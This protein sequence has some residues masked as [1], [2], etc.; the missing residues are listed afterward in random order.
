MTD[1]FDF[2]ALPA[3]DILESIEFEEIYQARVA[4]FKALAPQYADA[5][6]LQSDPLSVC[7][8]VESYRELLLR[9]RIN[10][11]VQSNLLATA[12]DADL[13]QLGLFYGVLRAADEADSGFRQRIR[14]KT[15][16]S[17][18]AGS[19]D[20]YRN[21]ALSAAPSAIRDVE[22]DSPE[23]GKVRVA[24]LFHTN[25][26]PITA[27]E[28]V[29]SHVLSDEVKVL[30]DSVDVE[31]AEAIEVDVRAD[32]YLNPNTPV[33]VFEQLEA[34]LHAAW[35]TELALGTVMTPSWL[36]AQLHIA[37]VKHVEIHTPASLVEVAA[38]Q[39]VQ[40]RQVNLCLKT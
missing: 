24:V 6:A 3:P 22:V 15:L 29:R 28:Q 34:K 20:H 1:L 33:R 7:L 9:Q 21:A 38:N 17:S 5:L 26:N 2:A 12:Q 18:T 10:E 27:L 16:A 37:G 11:A 19:K 35:Q 39:Y 13:D 32:I 31:L 23:P 14:Q 36:S 40:L 30:T 4:R 25:E 8:Q